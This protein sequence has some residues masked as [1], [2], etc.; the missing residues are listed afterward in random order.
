MP[1]INNLVLRFVQ[2]AHPITDD[3]VAIAH[4]DRELIEL[5]RIDTAGKI[6][7]AAD[8]VATLNTRRAALRVGDAAGDQ[9][10]GVGA[11]NMV[12]RARIKLAQVPVVNRQVA[13]VPGG[14]G[15]ALGQLSGDVDQ[16]DEVEFHAAVALGL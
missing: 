12:L 4:R 3:V 8:L 11:P 13:N 15:A 16:C 1:V 14:G 10:V 7:M 2:Y 9:R 6:P 5:R